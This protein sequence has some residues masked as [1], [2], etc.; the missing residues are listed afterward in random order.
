M[1]TISLPTRIS[2]LYPVFALT[3]ALSTAVLAYA[4]GSSEIELKNLSALYAT[5][6]ASLRQQVVSLSAD[7]KNSHAKLTIQEQQITDTAAKLASLQKQQLSLNSQLGTTTRQLATAQNQLSSSASEL[8]T[9][10]A[11]PPLFSFANQS[12]LTDISVKEAAV[13][14]LVSTAYGYIQTIYGTPYL[15]DSVKITFVNQ[16]NIAGSSGEILISNGPKGIAIDIHLKDFNP[17]DFQD[18]NTVIHEMIHAFHGIAVFQTSAI[19]EGET[20]AATDAVMAK[21]TADNK[22]PDF[23]HLYLQI[24]DSEYQQLNSTL[25]IQAD[26]ARFYASDNIAQIY[27]VIGQAWYKMYQA[28][29]QIFSTINAKYYKKVQNGQTATTALALQSIRDSMISVAGT[30]IDQYLQT[31]IAFNP[32]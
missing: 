28:D 20:V 32:K 22:L 3:F 31:Q 10:R 16:Y 18:N 14:N 21:M 6:D 7:S 19:E 25:A 30:P 17:D 11:R 29:P 24:P 13:K 5:R 9:L 1:Y 15:L 12:N 23:G 2:R 26:N 4:W 8:Q 27:Q